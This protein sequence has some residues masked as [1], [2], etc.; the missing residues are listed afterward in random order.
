MDATKT[1]IKVFRAILAAKGIMDMKDELVHQHSNGRTTHASALKAQELQEL[2]DRLQPERTARPRLDRE[3]GNRMRRRIL[4]LCYTLGY[5]NMN[6]ATGKQTVDWDRLNA[7]MLKYGYL[8]KPLNQY[9]LSELPRL[10][11]QFETFVKTTL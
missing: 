8:H 6:P 5:T 11:S 7:W 9:T 10:V 2:I 3:A 4:S 1:Q